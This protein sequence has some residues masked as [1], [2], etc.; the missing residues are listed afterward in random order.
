[1]NEHCQTF[2]IVSVLHF[3]DRFMP[4]VY[5]IDQKVRPPKNIDRVRTNFIG[6]ARM[7]SRQF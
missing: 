4:F 3:D 6:P 1:M 7:L 5:K 2:Q